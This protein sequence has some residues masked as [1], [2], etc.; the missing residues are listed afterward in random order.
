[1][2]T[3]ISI[4]ES[5]E[6]LKEN[7]FL[8]KV[9]SPQIAS[10]CK[11]GQ[12]C[13]IK[14]SETNYPLLRR[15]FSICNV[16]DD[17]LYFMFDVHGEGTK[18]LAEKRKGDKLDILGPLGNSFGYESDFERAI[19]VAGGIG[20]A[21]FPFLISEMD[22]DKEVFTFLGGRNKEHIVTDWMENIFISTDDG[23]NG[24]HGNVVEL[25]NH[26]RQILDEKKVKI[27][28]CG[29]NPMLRALKE[30]SMEAG[31]DCELSTE[32]AMACGFG[33][34]QGCAIEDTTNKDK[35]KLVCV[36]G[37]VFDAKEIEI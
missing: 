29:P 37:P 22:E 21:P 9:K 3:E 18:I 12:F 16:E 30:F 11:P 15:P 6:K 27:F 32:C 8:I 1:M 13:N 5:L 10:N 28:A 23:S 19:I 2:I 26:N 20:A 34:C 33:I 24:F 14:V 31:Y 35:Y 25:L 4:V 7:I 17:Y 36:D